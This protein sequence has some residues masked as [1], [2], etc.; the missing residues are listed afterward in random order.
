MTDLSNEELACRIKERADADGRMILELLNRNKGFIYKRAR[1]FIDAGVVEID[2][3]QSLGFISVK[4]AVDRWDAQKGGKFISILNWCLIRELVNA[5][6]DSKAV[7][8][9]HNM[10]DEL[11]KYNNILR[12]FMELHQ[13]EPTVEE[14]AALLSVTEKKYKMIAEVYTMQTPSSLDAPIESHTD[15]EEISVGDTLPSGEDVEE[16]VVDMVYLAEIRKAV[17]YELSRL[18]DEQQEIIRLHFLCAV[19]LSRDTMP[20]YRKALKTL[21]S[22]SVRN[23]LKPFLTENLYSGT[24]Q[25]SFER[26]GT[27]QPERFVISHDDGRRDKK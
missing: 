19:P 21:R 4:Q 18:P 14:G 20:I 25:A 10:N 16:A 3:L 17:F 6:N 27:S 2:E 22:P 9:P 1:P 12:D 8:V 11:R 24:G 5:A 13:R 7:P 26:T 15:A 23:R